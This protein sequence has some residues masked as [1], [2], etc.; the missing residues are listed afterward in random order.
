VPITQIITILIQEM[1]SITPVPAMAIISRRIL[2]TTEELALLGIGVKEDR[3]AIIIPIII[4]TVPS[5]TKAA[6]GQ[7]IMGVTTTTLIKAAGKVTITSKGTGMVV[8]ATTKTMEDTNN[9][10]LVDKPFLNKLNQAFPSPTYHYTVKRPVE[11]GSFLVW[12]SFDWRTMKH[13]AKVNF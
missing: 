3:K 5:Q 9:I 4:T 13:K 7:A 8:M 2:I 1:A 6:V 10:S 11:S 12:S